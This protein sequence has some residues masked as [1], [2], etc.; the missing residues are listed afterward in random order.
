MNVKEDICVVWLKRDL[1]LHDNEA[2]VNAL[3]SG[4]RV[5]LLYVFEKLLLN[6]PHYSER[7][8]DF[9]KQSL[10]DM[11][12]DLKKYNTESELLILTN[13]VLKE[14]KQCIYL[15]FLRKITL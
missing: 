14:K 10:V 9:I 6:D 11:N 7:H 1:R 15:S 5:L 12:R 3:K 4:R 8:W 13:K 2:I